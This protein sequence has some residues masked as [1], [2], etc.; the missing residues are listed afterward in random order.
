MPRIDGGTAIVGV[1]A[2]V[3]LDGY[4]HLTTRPYR[5][6]WA[7]GSASWVRYSG[8]IMP[9]PNQA[10]DGSTPLR[11]AALEARESDL[12]RKLERCVPPVDQHRYELERVRTELASVRNAED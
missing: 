1:A 9:D 6:I 4:A 3:H 12:L 2:A 7:A 11:I 10:A 5:H 8:R